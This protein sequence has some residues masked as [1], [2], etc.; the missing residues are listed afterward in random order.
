MLCCRQWPAR[1]IHL[2]IISAALAEIAR[3]FVKAMKEH[4]ENPNVVSWYFITTV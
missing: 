3:S 4:S 2:S 1:V